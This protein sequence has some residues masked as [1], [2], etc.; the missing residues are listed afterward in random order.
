MNVYSAGIS[1]CD[2]AKQLAN[3]ALLIKALVGFLYQEV[4]NT[5][6]INAITIKN[7]NSAD[8]LP[9]T[10]QTAEI[11]PQAVTEKGGAMVCWSPRSNGVLEPKGSVLTG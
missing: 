11:A 2:T 6:H 7:Q 8:F 5:N 10:P 9:T 1:G 3:A 4:E